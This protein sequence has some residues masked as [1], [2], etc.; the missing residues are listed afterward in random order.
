MGSPSD[1]VAK[2]KAGYRQWHES[3]GA[4]VKAWLDLMVDDVKCYSL[5]GGAPGAEFTAA[6]TSKKDFERYFKGLLEDWEMI[7]YKTGEFIAEGDR[8][9][10]RG[11]TAWAEPQDRQGRRH[12]Q[13]RFLDVSRGQNLGV[14]R[15]L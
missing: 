4:S 12:A 7:N 14:P 3:K 5:A 9:A 13:G 15:V 2:L 6:I 1:N 11:S 10:M 8:V